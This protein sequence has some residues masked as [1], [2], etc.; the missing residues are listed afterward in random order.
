MVG[1]ADRINKVKPSLSNTGCRTCEYLASLTAEDRQAFD[2]WLARNYSTVQLWEMCVEDGLEVSLS[3]L[4]SHIKH[5]EP[6]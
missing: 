4:R 6:L 2:N 3:A 1:L 5:H